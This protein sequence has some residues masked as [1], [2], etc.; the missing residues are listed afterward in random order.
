MKKPEFPKTFKPL[1][2]HS[3]ELRAQILAMLKKGMS[4]NEIARQLDISL[5]TVGYHVGR[6]RQAG[7][8][9]R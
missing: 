3:G 2:R 6:L 8:Y 9:K 4:Q 5:G 7:A 1:T